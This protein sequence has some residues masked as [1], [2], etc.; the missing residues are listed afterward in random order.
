[1]VLRGSDKSGGEV[2]DPSPLLIE[3]FSRAWLLLWGIWGIVFRRA[4]HLVDL[5]IYLFRY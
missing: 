3:N 1:M 5:Q 2:G 4:C